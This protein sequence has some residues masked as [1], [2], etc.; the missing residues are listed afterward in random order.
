[1]AGEVILLCLRQ[2]LLAE[3][4]QEAIALL[5]PGQPL[6]ERIITGDTAPDRLHEARSSDAQ[7]LHKPV[8]A[9]RF[10]GRLPDK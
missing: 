3:S 5:G 9:W 8:S 6:P 10:S 1:M 2:C 7:L 4:A